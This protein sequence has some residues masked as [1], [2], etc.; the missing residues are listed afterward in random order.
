MVRLNLYTLLLAYTMNTDYISYYFSPL[1]SMWYLII[2]FTMLVGSRYN[3]RTLF[4]VCKIFASM[5][6]VTWFMS[7]PWLLEGVFGFLARFCNIR[8][9]AKEWAFRVGLDLWIVYIGML[10]AL[11]V[12][13]TRELRLTDH[14]YWPLVHKGA[15]GASGLVL[16]WFFAFELSQ[17]DKFAY[18][19]WHPYISFLP[20]AA[21]VALRNANAI[22]RSASSRAFAFIGTCSLETFI[23][24]YHFWLAGDTKGILLVIPGT[25]WRPLNMIV[26]SI[27]FIYVSHRVSQAT[28]Q[29]TKWICDVPKP[30]SL[31]T[32]AEPPTTRPPPEPETVEGQEVIFLAPQDSTG[33]KDNEGNAL[34]PE[35]DTPVRPLRRWVDRLADGPSSSSTT[36]TSSPG[37]RVIYGE[38]EWKPGVKAKILIGLGGMWLLNMMWHNP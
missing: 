21:F 16:L 18:N 28:G 15:V 5:A 33:W 11:A 12:I 26:T 6:I 38:T 24:Q 23:I 20:I 14:P 34:P 32:V 30:P 1:V 4:L 29:I 10:S 27:L 25:R 7:E 31:P 19:A 9:S 2:Y 8:W 37:F 35:P 36:T 17:P 22:L 13:K 3:D